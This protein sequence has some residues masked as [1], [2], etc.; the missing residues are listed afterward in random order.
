[1]RSA[2]LICPCQSLEYQKA[3][4][5]HIFT[6]GNGEESKVKTA[7]RFYRV[8]KKISLMTTRFRSKMRV[9]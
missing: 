8:K 2:T 5:I 7:E 1:M 9:A 6:M 3:N 4:I